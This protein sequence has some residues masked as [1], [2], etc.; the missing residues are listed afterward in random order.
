MEEH[1]VYFEGAL[2][3]AL[4]EILDM[5]AFKNTV[6]NLLIGLFIVSPR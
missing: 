4:R 5:S 6:A 1:A 3:G 2:Q